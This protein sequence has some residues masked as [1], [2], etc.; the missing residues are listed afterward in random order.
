[1]VGSDALSQLGMSRQVGCFRHAVC[2]RPR[3][4][5]PVVM[6]STMSQVTVYTK[7]DCVQ[8]KMTYRALDKH[9]LSY[10]IVDI[11]E[12]AAAFDYVV[13]LGYQQVP[14]VVSGNDHWA[15]FRPERI[16]EVAKSLSEVSAAV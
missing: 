10:E 13:S 16:A 15:G 7:P 4:R 8:C 2:F 3:C 12:D 1:M 6:S 11:S 14:V 5:T 9:D